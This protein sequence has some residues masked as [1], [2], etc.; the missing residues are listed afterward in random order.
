MEEL[1]TRHA[2]NACNYWCKGSYHRHETRQ[3]NR[4][5]A[6]LVKE[7]MSGPY[8]LLLQKLA[9]EGVSMHM[10]YVDTDVV[11]SNTAEEGG[12]EDERDE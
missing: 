10:L 6:V 2:S 12:D 3:E 1:K 11:T 7:L 5:L 9:E 4:A 8:V